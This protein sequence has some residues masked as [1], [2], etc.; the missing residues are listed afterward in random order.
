[1][2]CSLLKVIE[3]EHVVAIAVCK[4]QSQDT[5]Q[6]KLLMLAHLYEKSMPF[7]HELLRSHVDESQ[8]NAKTVQRFVW[9][10]T[11]GLHILA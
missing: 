1:M 5:R 11:K 9:V 2:P 8:A 4:I 7:Q 6:V 3:T 10:C